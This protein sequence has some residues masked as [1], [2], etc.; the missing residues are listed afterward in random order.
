VLRAYRVPAHLDTAAIHD[1]QQNAWRARSR[2]EASIDQMLAEPVPARAVSVRAALAFLPASRRF[3]AAALALQSRLN[4]IAHPVTATLEPL[5]GDIDT[6]LAT[7]A[8]ALRARKAPGALPPLRE[9][10][11][12]LKKAL[13]LGPDP[14]LAA[15]VAETD[16]LVDGVVAMAEALR[17]RAAASG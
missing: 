8:D 7:L 16:L 14:D 13:D 11:V 5:A 2:A 4:R 1:A 15:L 6:A 12:A 10:Q 9:H 17:R 3:G